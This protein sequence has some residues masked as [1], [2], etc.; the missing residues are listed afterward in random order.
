MAVDRFAYE[1]TW[2]IESLLGEYAGDQYDKDVLVN[3]T[4]TSI[5]K[6]TVD[7][8]AKLNWERLQ[9]IKA[10]ANAQ[11]QASI[12]DD[13]ESIVT[14]EAIKIVDSA[15]EIKDGKQRC[16]IRNGH[17]GRQY[18]AANAAEQVAMKYIL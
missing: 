11:F 16:L 13:I 4:S 5:R 14:E 9:L 3:A 8:G 6:I 10:I 17:H 7:D 2:Q 15:T 18:I 12:I 1:T